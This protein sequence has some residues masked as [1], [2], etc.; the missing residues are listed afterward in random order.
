M[1]LE[2]KANPRFLNQE[3][4]RAWFLTDLEKARSMSRLNN[5]Y[6][7]V[8]CSPLW[9]LMQHCINT[10]KVADAHG[11]VTLKPLNVA[12]LWH[13]FCSNTCVLICLT[14]LLLCSY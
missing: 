6:T 3:D 14:K 12:F 8:C 9:Y 10:L 4:P 1:D 5:L 11:K 2:T 13:N 7:Q